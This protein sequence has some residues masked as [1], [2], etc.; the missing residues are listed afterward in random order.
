MSNSPL[1]GTPIRYI[2]EFSEGRLF[3]VAPGEL[4][5]EVFLDGGSVRQS[6]WYRCPCGSGGVLDNHVVNSAS[7]VDI[8][9]S[10]VC[11]SGCH[12][13]IKNGVIE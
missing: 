10:I 9:P 2:G 7:P 11:P 8:T 5:L 3:Y 6:W 12:Y 1:K 13:F 4:A